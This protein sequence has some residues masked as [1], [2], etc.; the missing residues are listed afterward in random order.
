V[1]VLL[2]LARALTEPLYTTIP[3][4][5]FHPSTKL[6]P[7]IISQPLHLPCMPSSSS[8]PLARRCSPG[9]TAHPHEVLPALMH[10]SQ[11]WRRSTRCGWTW[12]G[13]GGTQRR[14]R[15]WSVPQQRSRC[16]AAQGCMPAACALRQRAVSA[17]VCLALERLRQRP[18]MLAD[19][20]NC[21]SY[22]TRTLTFW[23]C[24]SCTGRWQHCSS[25][26]LPPLR[27][28]HTYRRGCKRRRRP[29]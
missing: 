3:T 17:L 15:R 24:R 29:C 9:S 22:R 25:S 1:C 27:R 28:S 10:R 13:P 21:L 12:H 19:C 26:W 14:T 18:L 20:S 5:L 16:V 11:V 23:T 6:V 8:H 4:P 7:T 2:Y